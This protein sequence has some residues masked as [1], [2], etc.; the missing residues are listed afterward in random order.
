[1]KTLDDLE[2][3]SLEWEKQTGYDS[4]ATIKRVYTRAPSGAYQC[5]WPGCEFARQDAAKL[6]KHVHTGHGTSSLPPAAS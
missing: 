4:I 2:A 5:V 6:W 3:I 1:M